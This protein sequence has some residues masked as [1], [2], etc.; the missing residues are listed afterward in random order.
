[1]DQ[2]AGTLVEILREVLI[3]GGSS[4]EVSSTDSET[5]SFCRTDSY[6]LE[7]EQELCGNLKSAFS[8]ITLNSNQSDI[9]IRV[10]ENFISITFC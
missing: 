10:T 6:T 9:V 4:L 7:K 1:M 5:V 3:M 2:L 8:N